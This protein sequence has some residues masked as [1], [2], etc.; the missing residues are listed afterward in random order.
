[1]YYFG[2]MGNGQIQF[3]LYILHDSDSNTHIDNFPNHYAMILW[4][5][6][7]NGDIAVFSFFLGPLAFCSGPVM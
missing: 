7:Q 3:V 2:M 1:M 5:V 6:S 4:C